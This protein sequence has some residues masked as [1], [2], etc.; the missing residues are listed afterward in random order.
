MKL[1]LNVVNVATKIQH[2]INVNYRIQCVNE[3]NLTYGIV[4]QIDL[5]TEESEIWS[6]IL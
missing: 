1:Q 6:A 4:R 2:Q 5:E 3:V